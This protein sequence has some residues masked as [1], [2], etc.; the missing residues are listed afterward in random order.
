[1]RAPLFAHISKITHFQTHFSQKVAKSRNEIYTFLED[2]LAIYQ[3]NTV[4]TWK[5]TE[6][7]TYV[8]FCVSM[9]SRIAHF[10]GEKSEESK[11]SQDYNYIF[12][13]I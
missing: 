8:T 7:I 2:K 1:M 5:S 4:L 11:K 13:I 10:A 3:K 9:F 12:Y 6:F